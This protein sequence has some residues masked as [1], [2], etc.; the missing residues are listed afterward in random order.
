M[1][2][3]DSK[4]V[5]F[6]RVGRT[7]LVYQTSDGLDTGWFN[8]VSREFESLPDRYRLDVKDGLADELRGMGA[9]ANSSAAPNACPR[10]RPRT[11]SITR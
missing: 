7:L 4:T 6:L 2:I 8:P 1:T 9:G 3:P 11:C 10:L 5:D